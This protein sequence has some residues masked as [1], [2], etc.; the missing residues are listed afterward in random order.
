M[1]PCDK[2]PSLKTLQQ[3]KPC[4]KRPSLKTLRQSMTCYADSP[5]PHL[6]MGLHFRISILICWKLMSMHVWTKFLLELKLTGQQLRLS[7]WDHFFTKVIIFICVHVV[8]ISKENIISIKSWATSHVICL[9]I[10]DVS[11]TVSNPI[12]P[13]CWGHRWSLKCQ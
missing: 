4:D 9:K 7:L 12:R 13:R 10:T 3:R 2:R 6:I 11:G 8:I 5:F 1:K